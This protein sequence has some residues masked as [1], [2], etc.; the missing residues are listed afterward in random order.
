MKYSFINVL[1]LIT[2]INKLG[3]IK[4]AKKFIYIYKEFTFTACMQIKH[5]I[6]RFKAL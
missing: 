1:E 4:N 5:I 3:D 6:R 2:S